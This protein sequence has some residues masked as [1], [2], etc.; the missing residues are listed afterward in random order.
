VH[1]IS[2]QRATFDLPEERKKE[3]RNKNIFMVHDEM[4]KR[5]GEER[6]KFFF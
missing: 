2:P 5:S 3:K 4:E 6:R 1:K